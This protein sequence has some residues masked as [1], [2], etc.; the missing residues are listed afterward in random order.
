METKYFI[1]KT[2][3]GQMFCVDNLKSSMLLEKN[4]FQRS[5]PSRVIGKFTF[6]NKYAQY[7]TFAGFN[8]LSGFSK[9]V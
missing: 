2:M 6:A 8:T 4:H 9:G 3:S 1:G 7:A 5:I